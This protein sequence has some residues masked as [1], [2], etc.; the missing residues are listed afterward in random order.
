MTPVWFSNELTKGLQIERGVGQGSI[1]SPDLFNLYGDSILRPVD[2]IPEGISVNDV[3]INIRYTNDTILIASSEGLWRLLEEANENSDSNASASIA[4]RRSAWSSQGRSPL[5]LA[6]WQL[7][8][9]RLNRS[10]PLTT[11]VLLSPRMVDAENMETNQFS[12]RGF[13]ENEANPLRPKAINVEQDLRP[14][15]IFWSTLLYGSWTLTA[16]TRKKIQATEIWFYIRMLKISYI[17]RVTNNDVLN[18][19]QQERL[20]L[21]V[22][23]GQNKFVG[24]IIRKESI[25]ISV[26]MERY[27]ENKRE[28]GD[29]NFL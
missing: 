12:Q 25:K 24:H 10:T 5:R 3:R 16:E 27:P 20:L 19:I 2:Y 14:Q 7:E 23:R 21:W 17:N 28:D 18:H 26:S 8:I 6:L 29:C 4:K 15:N 1:A 13:Q 22:Q 9:P 11:L